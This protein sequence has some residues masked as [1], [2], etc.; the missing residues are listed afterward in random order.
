MQAIITLLILWISTLSI[1][2]GQGNIVKLILSFLGLAGSL[3]SIIYYIYFKI[4][5]KAKLKDYSRFLL[6]LTLPLLIVLAFHLNDLSDDSNNVYS[7]PQS[8]GAEVFVIV[9]GIIIYY[10]FR[11]CQNLFEWK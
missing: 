7:D 4:K 9:I 3:A 11:A 8:F 10:V 5:K 2:D 6:L 1:F